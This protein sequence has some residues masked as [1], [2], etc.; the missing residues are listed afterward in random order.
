MKKR[1]IT[2]GVAA[3]L[4]GVALAL[5]AWPSSA[6]SKHNKHEYRRDYYA[7]QRLHDIQV[8]LEKFAVKYGLNAGGDNDYPGTIGELADKMDYKLP[9]NPFIWD[10]QVPLHQVDDNAFEPGGIVYKPLKNGSDQIVGYELGIF[11]DRPNGG[12]DLFEGASVDWSK[13]YLD[14]NMKR[15]GQ[16]EGLIL[17]LSSWPGSWTVN[18]LRAALND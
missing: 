5:A 11:G 8:Q 3:A 4:T 16:P 13:L 18:D 9:L 12:E 17:L 1:M 10:Q 14:Q 7:R 2:L 15:D 6:E